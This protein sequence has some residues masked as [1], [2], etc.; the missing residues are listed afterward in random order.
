[1]ELDKENTLKI[2]LATDNHLGYLERDPIRGND[3]IVTFEE[4]LM[5]ANLHEADFVLLGGD[6]F[7]ENQPSR[8]TLYSTMELLRK[9]C[10][11][12]RP[13][14]LE[15]LSNA[16]TVFTNTKFP[17][18]NYMSP[19]YNISMPVFSIHG[20]HDDPAGNGAKSAMDIL[21]VAGLVNYFGQA[22]SIESIEVF[23]VLL[24]KGKTKLALYGLGHVKDERLH[25]AFL[26]G[27][28]KLQRPEEDMESWFNIFVLHQNRRKHGP[29]NYIPEQFLADFLDLV[30]WGHEHDCLIDPTPHETHRFYLTQPGSSI[31]TS[32]AEGEAIKKHVALVEI[33]ERQ[34]RFTKIPLQTVR[35]F[36]FNSIKLKDS[37]LNPSREDQIETYLAE[38]VEGLIQMAQEEL[39]SNEK[40][41]PLPLIRLKVDYSGGYS[42][43]NSIRFGQRFV[44]QV[45]N[46][47]ET[48]MFHR[49]RQTYSVQWRLWGAGRRLSGVVVGGRS[50]GSG[51]GSE[52][53]AEHD[54]IDGLFDQD[55]TNKEDAIAV[56]DLIEMQAD[57]Q[58][59][60][61][62][63]DYLMKEA[64]NLFV[65][66]KVTEAFSEFVSTSL[67]ATKEFLKKEDDL[68]DDTIIQQI[69]QRRSQLQG[70]V[71]E[72][73]LAAIASR[74][75]TEKSSQRRKDSSS[76]DEMDT[77][78][79]EIR[80]R[81]RGRRGRAGRGRAS[82][83]RGA[84]EGGRGR[85][86][87]RGRPRGTTRGRRGGSR[88]VV[89]GP[90][91]ISDSDSDEQESAVI[92]TS[93]RSATRMSGTLPS[94]Q[95]GESRKRPVLY[96][97]DDDDDGHTQ[98]PKKSKRK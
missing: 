1:M 85:G 40:A 80:S 47:K 50:G 94:S 88:S 21:S 30:V 77:S 91:H 95:P 20:N 64:V 98:P 5:L 63:S 25:R 11:G 43:I 66:K 71:E 93:S 67:D 23:P 73:H 56:T 16:D 75:A 2:L 41:P 96:V 48:L 6:L 39:R 72:E 15:F 3:S 70:Q 33:N 8:K 46:P 60:V 51:G 24:Q 18:A 79:E 14:S 82:R 89:E 34:F 86:R 92:F 97:D 38:K 37:R 84:S 45:A 42:Q 4:I 61:L 90:D 9:H 58:K 12:D 87:P 13:C 78:E 22:H 57:K 44:N 31:A 29:T 36:I 55:Q 76:N 69:S 7:H 19:N 81:G 26:K 54:D 68:S 83:A 49:Q 28:V 10:M 74:Q 62:L 27:R 53:P 32:L 52:G 59:M 65:D 35:V 17:L